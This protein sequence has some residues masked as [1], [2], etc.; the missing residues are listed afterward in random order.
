M[1]FV[2]LEVN[3]YA[4]DGGTIALERLNIENKEKPLYNLYSK[5]PFK[6]QTVRFTENYRICHFLILYISKNVCKVTQTLTW[7]S[8][9]VSF[10]F[11]MKCS[12]KLL[13]FEMH[14]LFADSSC[15]FR[16]IAA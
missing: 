5:K 10:N 14:Q 16:A 13:H 2:R 6:S 9:T 8:L 4:P 7:R 1:T 11:W 15:D 3:L 12:Y